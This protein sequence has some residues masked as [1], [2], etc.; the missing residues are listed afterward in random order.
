[1]R[2]L[3][4]LLDYL[5]YERSKMPSAY[6]FIWGNNASANEVPQEEDVF[7]DDALGELG[8][9]LS[10]LPIMP[11]NSSVPVEWA[12]GVIAGTCIAIQQLI[13]AGD[14]RFDPC[15]AFRNF[16]NGDGTVARFNVLTLPSQLVC[17]P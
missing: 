16:A 9:E 11:S 3:E 15:E 4:R 6:E 12:T 10:A 13:P 2:A 5:K 17:L 14:K 7:G 1:M 8:T